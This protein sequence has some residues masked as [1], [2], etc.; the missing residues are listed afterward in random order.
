MSAVWSHHDP[1]LSCGVV[2]VQPVTPGSARSITSGSNWAELFSAASQPQQP[3]PAPT[4]QPQQ[5]QQLLQHA[6]P[7]VRSLHLWQ[8]TC[9]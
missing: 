7:P 2:G 6:S 3:A 1:E 5:Q 9:V 4:V 8:T